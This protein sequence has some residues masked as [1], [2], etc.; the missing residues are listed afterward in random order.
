M[1]AALAGKPERALVQPDGMV[2]IKID[3]DTGLAILPGQ[4]G[5][6]A[7]TFRKELVPKAADANAGVSP[8]IFSGDAAPATDVEIREDLF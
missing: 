5:G 7:E 2:T 4:P 6:I 8:D 3:P 1:K